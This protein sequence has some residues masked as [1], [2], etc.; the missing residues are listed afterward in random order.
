MS[1]ENQSFTYGAGDQA[2]EL[3]VRVPVWTC[4]VCGDQYTDSVAE[5]IRHAAVCRHLGRLTPDKIIR[6]RKTYELSQSEFADL[7][8]IGIASIKR[9]EAG[10]QIQSESFDKFMRLLYD[11]K[12][13]E[14]LR[15]PK[16]I[17][18]S[19]SGGEHSKFRTRFS[20]EITA[21]ASAFALRRK[22]LELASG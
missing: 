11:H 9:W 14:A 8:G 7:T 17:A 2:V 18:V 3:S 10:N 4:E 20:P 1:Y 5:E 15:R 12:N 16:T 22:P 13:V 6:L 19:G 21:H